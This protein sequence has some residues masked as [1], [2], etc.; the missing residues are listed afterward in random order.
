[1]IVGKWDQFK[2]NF[3]A[4]IRKN[5][6]LAQDRVIKKQSNANKDSKIPELNNELEKLW[7]DTDV[8]D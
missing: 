1:M 7:S 3:D 4:R 2:H 6:P 5:A 8:F